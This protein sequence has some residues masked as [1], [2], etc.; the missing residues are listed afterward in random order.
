MV[1]TN[2]DY[3]HKG[4]IRSQFKVLHRLSRKKGELMCAITGIPFFYRQFGYEMAMDLGGSRRGYR[5]HVP[6][7]EEDKTETYKLR[8]ASPSD[9]PFINDMYDRGR[10]RSLISCPRSESVW[11]YEMKIQH[12]T[13]R[14]DMNIIETPDG[15]SVGFLWHENRLHNSA[16]GAFWYDLKPGI[17]WAAVTPTIIRHLKTKGEALAAMD[18]EKDWES[19]SLN[20][21]R[22]HPAYDAAEQNLP[23][24]NDPYAWYIRI[25]DLVGFL[26]LITP[27][28][29]RRFSESNHAGYTGELLLDFY[30]SGIKIQIEGGTITKIED[31][32]PSTDSRGDLAFPGLSFLN[33]V[34]GSRS[35]SELKDF[36]P[37]CYSRK[38][39]E[40]PALIEILFPKKPSYVLGIV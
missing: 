16:L 12:K 2:R 40:A 18:E 3:R 37:D 36:Y 9:I 30:R 13:F 10:K 20:L 27:V 25:P 34:C 24:K 6:K 26:K 4:L 31:W 8:L 22:H 29:N 28:L 5:T 39:S 19:F 35:F 23:E 7:L 38:K 32:Q 11:R 15:E 1:S 14:G 21:G 17:S 33:L